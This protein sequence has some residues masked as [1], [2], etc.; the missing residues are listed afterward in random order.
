MIDCVFEISEEELVRFQ[1][2]VEYFME[3]LN[4]LKEQGIFFVAM[5]LNVSPFYLQKVLK[6]GVKEVWNFFLEKELLIR[7]FVDKVVGECRL[8]ETSY[9]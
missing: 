3:F 2:S 5:Y 8:L 7:I 6:R 4:V 1:N 9:E